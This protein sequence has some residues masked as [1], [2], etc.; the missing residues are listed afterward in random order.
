MPMLTAQLC[1]AG[2]ALLDWSAKDLAEASGVSLDTLRSFESGR[3]RSLRGDNDAAVRD[4]FR[5]SGVRFVEHGD[6][7][8]G[9]GVVL[10]TPPGSASEG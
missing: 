3:S 4:A 1:K 6:P 9:V 10:D 5:A 2:R 7:S 8:P